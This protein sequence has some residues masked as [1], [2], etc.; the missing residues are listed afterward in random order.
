MAIFPLSDTLSVPIQTE[1][2]G[3]KLFSGIFCNLSSTEKRFAV[4]SEELGELSKNAIK[5]VDR[6]L[7]FSD[8]WQNLKFGGFFVDL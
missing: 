3:G 7:S 8:I 2:F 4:L 6:R 1:E 5:M